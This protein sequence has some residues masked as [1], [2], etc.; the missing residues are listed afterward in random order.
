MNTLGFMVTIGNSIEDAQRSGQLRRLLTVLRHY[1]AAIPQVYYFSYAHET[2]SNYTD[3]PLLR[4]RIQVLARPSNISNRVYSLLIPYYW[5]KQIRACNAILVGQAVGAVPAILGR[6]LFGVPFVPIYGY[7]YSGFAR[8][9]GRIWQARFL[10]LVEM[11][12]AKAAT[13]VI[14]RTPELAAEL[15]RFV[16]KEKIVL[17]PNGVDTEFFRPAATPPR[18]EPPVLLFVGRLEPQKNLLAFLEA[19]RLVKEELPIRLVVI[20]EGSL[21]E[22]LQ[23]RATEYGLDVALL[24]TQ[25][26]EQLPGHMQ[27]AD[28]FVLPSLIEGHP[29]A[30]LEAMS[31]GLPCLG[32]DTQGIRGLIRDG[33]T[34][35][36]CQSSDPPSLAVGLHRLFADWP[37]AWAC[38][39]QARALVERQFSLEALLQ[40]ELAVLEQVARAK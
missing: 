29:K 14:V 35:I 11:I 10:Y 1:A 38:G 39:R 28:A 7:S 17:V 13:R 21:R 19:M 15:E 26:Y 40:Q 27:V 8:S 32:T 37:A 12:A 20:G 5:K 22:S 4:E 36:L 24:G 2:I 3:E 30:L 31:A 9:H 25:P 33:E 23:Q 34:G 16:D 18:N 6:Y